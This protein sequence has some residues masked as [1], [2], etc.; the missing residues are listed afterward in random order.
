MDSNSSLLASPQLTVQYI[1]DALDFLPVNPLTDSFEIGWRW[2]TDNY[3]KFQIA[4]WGSLVV[5][6]VRLC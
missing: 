3:T 4:T 6:E 5:H 2:M 1:E